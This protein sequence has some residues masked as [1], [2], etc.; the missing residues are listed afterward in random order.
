MKGLVHPCWERTI[1]GIIGEVLHIGPR[2]HIRIQVPCRKYYRECS[3][4]RPASKAASLFV[5]PGS[6]RDGHTKAD[7]RRHPHKG[8]H[9][10]RRIAGLLILK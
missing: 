1:S 8:L 4:A 3:F 7:A 10:Y 6:R 5:K 9:T 2:D